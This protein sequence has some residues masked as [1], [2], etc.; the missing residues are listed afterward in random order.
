MKTN[1]AK[2]SPR[3]F[4]SSCNPLDTNDRKI[5][6]HEIWAQ[7]PGKYEFLPE[8]NPLVGQRTSL[9]N[10]FSHQPK[11]FSPWPMEWF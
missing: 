7:N 8:L 1:P 4:L 5:E 9:C 11:I 10:L 3:V 6:G 2:F